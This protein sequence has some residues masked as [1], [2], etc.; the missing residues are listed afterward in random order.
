M[1]DRENMRKQDELSRCPPA[2]SPDIAAREVPVLF[3][4]IDDV[5]CLN[6]VCGGRDAARFVDGA[7]IPELAESL[8]DAGC[9]AVLNAAHDQMGGR[10]RYV[11]SSTWRLHVEREDVI[12]LFSHCGLGFVADSMEQDWRTVSLEDGSRVDEIAEWLRRN[13]EFNTPFVAVDDTCSGHN[14]QMAADLNDHGFEGRAVI[15]V[16]WRGLQPEHV[17]PIV[18]ALRRPR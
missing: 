13:E 6:T 12:K 3:L 2:A 5:I 8:F 18:A 4:D 16:E 15:C 9:V 7:Q 10:V 17:E 1:I 11:I 14:I